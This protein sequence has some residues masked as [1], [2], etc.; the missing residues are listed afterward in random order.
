LLQSIVLAI[1][2]FLLISDDQSEGGTA[3]GGGVLI[4]FQT[5]FTV[6][7]ADSASSW[8]TKH[9]CCCY[10]FHFFT[11]FFSDEESEDGTAYGGGLDDDDDGACFGGTVLGGGYAQNDYSTLA[12]KP[13][14]YN[15]P[16]WVCS[17]GRIFLE[18]Y[19]PIY[20]QVGTLKAGC[21]EIL[22]RGVC[23]CFNLAVL[24]AARSPPAWLVPLQQNKAT[25][26]RS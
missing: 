7:H 10:L 4:W 24:K 26:F 3:Y 13:D 1:E 2:I 25:A 8:R 18:T 14:H 6:V 21:V 19:S 9:F 5:S 23:P 22:R 20:K 15:R 12:L 17:D 16:L 11:L